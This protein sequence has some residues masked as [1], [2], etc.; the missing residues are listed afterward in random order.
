M[1]ISP[2]ASPSPVHAANP[3]EA[4]PGPQAVLA[5]EYSQ[6]VGGKRFSA[7]ID[8]AGSGYAAVVPNLPGA[9]ASGPT[10]LAVE[11]RLGNQISFF[12]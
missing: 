10:V 6:E 1:Q 3:S 4:A 12:A 9:S 7:D 2:V 5:A 11:N 8:P